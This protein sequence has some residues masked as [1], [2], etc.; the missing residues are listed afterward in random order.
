[1]H[2]AAVNSHVPSPRRNMQ[3]KNFISCARDKFFSLHVPSRAPYT[4]HMGSYTR[5]TCHPAEVRIPPLPPAEAGTQFSDPGGMQ[6][7]VDLC[8]VKTD[9]LGFEPATCQ[10]QVHRT[11]A[12]TCNTK[13][14][15]PRL[16]V[17][18]LQLLLDHI[19][20]LRTPMPPIVTDRIAWSVG[21]S[22]TLSV[23]HLVSP[24]KTCEAI[25]KPFTLRT[26]VGPWNHLCI[27]YSRALQ[28]EYCIVGIPHN[29]A[30]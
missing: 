18:M 28:A 20:V 5:V 2:T 6:G 22:V 4:C 3:K 13:Q 27:L 12:P 21:L 26:R 17:E 19:A 9:R 30:I 15:N 14:G 23:C 25:E 10:S 29:T 11:A 1:M 24:A 8:Y 7:W 16:C